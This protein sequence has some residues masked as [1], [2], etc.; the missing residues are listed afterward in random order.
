MPEI[1]LQHVVSCSSEDLTHKA[2]NLLTGETY[3]KWRGSTAGERQTSVI[4]QFEKASLIH[5]IDVGNEGSAF[6][7]ILVGL[8]SAGSADDYQVILVTSSFMSPVESKSGTNTNRVRMFG[9]DKLTKGVTSK[10][11]DRV[12]IVCSQPFN[13][14]NTYGLSFIKFHSPPE[15]GQE[16]T[17]PKAEGSSSKLGHFRLKEEGKSTSIGPGSYF[18]NRDKE[19]EAQPLTGAAAVRAASTL[20]AASMTSSVTSSQAKQSPSPARTKQPTPKRKLSEE[21]SS[22]RKEPEKGRGEVKKEVKEQQV[23]PPPVKKQRSEAEAAPKQS[24]PFKKLMQGVTFVL[25]GYQNPFRAELRDKA[26]DMG[27]KY[28]PDWGPGCTHLICAFANTPKYNQV[29]GKGKI[30]TKHWIMDSHRKKTLMPWKKYQLHSGES[31]DEDESDE[32]ESD[33]EEEEEEWDPPKKKPPTKPEAK[34][35]PRGGKG[36]ASSPS[37]GKSPM[38]KAMPKKPDDDDDYGGSTEGESD[39]E[40][41]QVTKATRRRIEEDEDSSGGDTEDELRRIQGKPAKDDDEYSGSTEEETSDKEMNGKTKNNSDG[42][43]ELPNFFS[44]KNFFVYGSFDK[45][46][47]R[48]VKRFIIAFGGLLQDYMKDNVQYV[49]T[50]STW[51]DNFDQALTENASLAFV[52]PKWLYTCNEKSKFVPYQP[53]VIV[54]K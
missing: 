5:S 32:D 26:L 43:P 46:E 27:A 3:R 18:K 33:T 28:K 17:P 23:K 53:Y 42:I 52:R 13:K 39:S 6:I 24:V 54:P 47:K 10:K 50:N 4:L 15:P 48:Q 44:G 34:G 40:E 8:S 22:G 2:D 14:H 16:S 9:P 20:A 25:S 35:S 12:K 30:V 36:R 41:P 51:D 49:I 38:K 37:K 1:K 11:W 45:E 31:S 7:E 29:K 21:E 19:K